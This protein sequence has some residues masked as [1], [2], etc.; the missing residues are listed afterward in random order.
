MKQLLPVFGLAFSLL[1][2]FAGSVHAQWTWLYPRPQ[3]HTLYDV[4]FLTDSIA[5]AV[6]ENA[7]VM[8]T[9]D[10]GTTWSVS[11]KTNDLTTAL[12]AV[13]AIDAT[14]AVAVGADGVVLRTVDAGLTWT[15][16]PSGTTEDL[17]SVDAVGSLVVIAGDGMW[18]SIDGGQS[19]TPVLTGYA[20]T[21][22]DVVSPTLAFAVSAFPEV[23][24]KSTDGG[25]TWSPKGFPYLEDPRVAFADV[26]NGVVSSA[27]GSSVIYYFTAD[28]GQT[29]VERSGPPVD[30]HDAQSAKEIIMVDAQTVLFA[31]SG[32]GCDPSFVCFSYGP[33]ARTTDGAATW[34]E[35]SASRP[36]F[37][38]DRNSSGTVLAVGEAGAVWRWFPSVVLEQ[39]GGAQY[40]GAF[41]TAMSFADPS[42]GMVNSLNFLVGGGPTETLTL[43]TSNAGATWTG[44]KFFAVV[45]NDLCHARGSNPAAYAVGRVQINGVFYTGVFKATD[46][47]ATWP[48][49]WGQTPYV[50][51]SAIE[52]ANAT[53]GV[54]VGSNGRALVIDNDV[55][56]PVTVPSPGTLLGVAFADPS[57]AV[58]IGVSGLFRTTDGGMTWVNVPAPAGVRDEIA[59]ASPTVGI[60]VGS[61]GILRST[62]AGL[63][64][65]PVV[66]SAGTG[67]FKVA[68]ASSTYG[69]IVG[70][71]G[72]FMETTDAGESWTVI[73]TPTSVGFVDLM[74]FGPRHAVLA[75]SNLGVFEYREDAVPTFFSSFEVSSRDFAA[76]LRWS[77]GDD[78]NLQEFR[79]VRDDR[80]VATLERASRAYKDEAVR[81]GTS[82]QY[83]L[84]AVDRDGSFTQSQ[85]V[86]VTI[87]RAAVALLP[88][89][90]NPFNPT[91]TISFTVPAK[92]PV[93]LT[94]HDVT[95]RVVATLLDGVRDA[96]MHSLTWD[97]TGVAS[98]VYF[99]KL[100]AGKTEVSQKMVLLK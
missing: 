32:G 46:N 92:M 99:T 53:H 45:L 26:Q 20:F 85:P 88:N 57:V 72:T 84:V 14:T 44:N 77:V 75:S 97:A 66:S 83:V 9:N 8:V 6:G 54:A 86:S 50:Q 15:L 71:L 27:F 33:L 80:V 16:Q 37:G 69:M 96:G 41:T 13:T 2:S 70:N 42:T 1:V 95:G 29:W 87:P 25:Q 55:V 58:A 73:P 61:N 62:D 52:F 5:I 39:I 48:V 63:T 23:L 17:G 60:A 21:D 7:T 94:V 12:H 47:G 30:V 3:G 64:W 34:D 28:G 74:C 4:E 24:L 43:R 100:R 19:W 91:T 11:P 68:F 10:G 90:P 67:L 51:M 38:M 82:Y 59:F 18:R 98:G 22:I 79:V 81:A 65:Q 40:D 93:Q 89:V 78:T 56:T 35:V 31:G 76:E 36:L 49:L